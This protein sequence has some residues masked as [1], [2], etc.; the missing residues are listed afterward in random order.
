MATDLMANGTATQANRPL[1][2]STPLGHDALLLVGFQGQ[3]AISHLFHFELDLLAD[4]QTDVVF[5]R[6]L[7]QAVTVRLAQAEAASRLFHGI[8][9]RVRQGNRDRFFTHYFLDIVPQAW[10]LTR[11]AQ[12]RIF[13]NLSTP[14][15]L[16]KVFAGLNVAFQV[17]GTFY[18]RDYCVQYR[19]TDFDFASRLM[20]EEGIWY[21]FRHT[22]QGHQMVLANTPLAH[23][24]LAEPNPILY[25][26]VTGGLRDD[27][28][29]TGWEK[30]QELRSG[31]VTLW[32]H[33]FELPYRHL[34][35]DKVVC[36]GVPVGMKDHKL[37]LAG[38]DK[39]EI[40][41]Y[42]G[43]YAQRFDG[44]NPGGGDSPDNLRRIYED[45]KRTAEIRLQ[46]ESVQSLVIRGTSNCRHLVSGYQFALKRHFNADG[47]YVLTRVE[48]SA[49]AALDYRAGKGGAFHYHNTFTCI[50]LAVPYRPAPRTARPFIRGTQTAVVVGPAGEEV[51]TDKYGRVK[52]QFP[53]DR[54][55]KY[56][57]DSSCWVRVAQPWAGKRWGASFWPRVGQEVIVAFQEGDPD[58]P[59]IVGSVY[60]ADQMPPYL[61]QGFDPKHAH[62]H[63]ISGIKSNTSAQGQGFNE[64]RFDDH[65][66]HEQFFVHAARDLDVW[67]NHDHRERILNDRHLIVGWSKDG[68][69]GGDCREMVH[70]DKHLL[71][72]GNQL[73]HVAGNVDLVIGG[74]DGGGF[75]EIVVRMDKKETI[76]RDEHLHVKQSQFQQVDKNQSLLVAGTRTEL[77]KSH[78]HLQVKGALKEKVGSHSLTVCGDRKERVQGDD[79]RHV[80]GARNEQVDGTQSLTVG[81]SQQEKVGQSHALEAVQEIHLKG[82]TKVILEAG[83]QLTIKA[84]GGF[85]DIGPAGVTIQGTTVMINSGGSAASGSG[86]SPTSPTDPEEPLNPTPPVDANEAKPLTPDVADDSKSGR[87]SRPPSWK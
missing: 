39:L 66:D 37:A 87:T 44:I 36:N 5:D 2:V 17:Q 10:L 71:V 46:A 86:S 30:A 42:P 72:R 55:G 80:Q 29:I 35:A 60:N 64:W 76:G 21:F 62:D 82:G 75:Q 16:R 57:A 15:I 12:C 85:V 24:V 84:A 52:V 49:G 59:I 19:E 40:F 41:D 22:A 61:G 31:K 70:Q 51:F 14:D 13:Q 67:V 32:D 7:G 9:Q 58:Q 4:N 45:N 77:V 25:E 68:K 28:R 53:W 18:P 3:E 54:Q 47:L 78:A 65:K 20:E 48:H 50:P 81:G 83:V 11:K 79:H 43:R 38:N 56:D 1:A 34:E 6:L 63:K 33:S 26:Q 27:F 23:P 69:H 73:A 74:G 8:V